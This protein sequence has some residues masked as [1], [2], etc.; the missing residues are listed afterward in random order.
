MVQ[1]TP[2]RNIRIRPESRGDLLAVNVSG[3][4]E[5]EDYTEIRWLLQR[6][7]ER[8]ET[9]RVLVVADDFIGWGPSGAW[10]RLRLHYEYRGRIEA[11]AVVGKDRVAEP[12]ALVWAGVTASPVETFPERSVALATAWLDA[13]ARDRSAEG[14]R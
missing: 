11:V 6:M 13:V 10:E 1:S 9:I 2:S 4:V 12:L 5:A 14:D 8:F 3:L 7:F